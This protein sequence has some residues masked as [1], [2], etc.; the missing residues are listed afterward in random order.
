MVPRS[1]F[2]VKGL[3]LCFE[4]KN[5]CCLCQEIHERVHTVDGRKALLRLM[6][7]RYHYDY[8]DP[9]WRDYFLDDIDG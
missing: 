6:R 7:D 2:G 9:P 5:R 8:T 1:H 3:H 4:M